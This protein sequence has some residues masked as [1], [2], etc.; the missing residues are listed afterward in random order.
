MNMAELAA[1][2]ARRMAAARAARDVTTDRSVEERASLQQRTPMA[3]HDRI[4]MMALRRMWR[5]SLSS[6]ATLPNVLEDPGIEL[7]LALLRRTA[8]L[9]LTFTAARAG[10]PMSSSAKEDSSL[11]LRKL[12]GRALGET[13]GYCN[14]IDL[15]NARLVNTAF[16]EAMSQRGFVLTVAGPLADL[17]LNQYP[18]SGD[19]SWTDELLASLTTQL[20][21]LRH[22]TSLLPNPA[23]GAEDRLLAAVIDVPFVTLRI[24]VLHFMCDV[25]PR[26]QQAREQFRALRAAIFTVQSSTPALIALLARAISIDAILRGGDEA[27]PV[28]VD[29][30]SLSLLTA[31][32]CKFHVRARHAQGSVQLP[33]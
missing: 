33:D 14:M 20:Q 19:S 24:D 7:E 8:P 26:I 11:M 29:L 28:G 15:R 17:I 9:L 16:V 31:V 2:A 21:Q 3:Q 27:P 30:R 18:D 13:L 12:S 23:L 1:V 5:S 25:R 10:G 22:F 6:V 4:G 32:T